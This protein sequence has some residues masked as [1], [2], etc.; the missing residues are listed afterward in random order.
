[1]NAMARMPAMTSDIDTPFI[2]FGISTSSNC[3]LIPARI[4]SARPKPIAVDAP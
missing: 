2:P 1:M 4:I 3:S